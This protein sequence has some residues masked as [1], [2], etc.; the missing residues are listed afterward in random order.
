VG[1]ARIR[2]REALAKFSPLLVGLAVAAIYAGST[3][4]WF[5]AGHSARDFVYVGQTFISRSDASQAIRQGPV[6]A[7]SLSGF[8]GQFFY[9]I[10]MDPRRAAPYID[11]AGYRYQR[12]AYPLAA[13]LIVLGN[14]S[15]VP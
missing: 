2:V 15:L 10:A 4:H 3:A 7:T 6:Q 5:H 11:L 12:I 1:I 13:R 9:F 14:R 8:D